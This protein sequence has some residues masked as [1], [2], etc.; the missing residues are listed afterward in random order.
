MMWRYHKD[1]PE[2]RIFESEADVPRGWVDS[3][4]KIKTVKPRKTDGNGS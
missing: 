2:G 4:A 3:P 1:C